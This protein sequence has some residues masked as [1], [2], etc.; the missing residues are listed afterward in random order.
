MKMKRI[1]GQSFKEAE[2]TGFSAEDFDFLPD[3]L[4]KKDGATGGGGTGKPEDGK[5]EDEEEDEGAGEGAAGTGGDGTGSG[6]A[7]D[8][9]DDSG[10]G[11]SDSF[12]LTEDESEAVIASFEGK[13]FNEAG[14]LLNEEGEVVATAAEIEESVKAVREEDAANYVNRVAS[15]KGV[16]LIDDNGAELEFSNDEEGVTRL[17][18]TTYEKGQQD[19]ANALFEKY[20][21]MEVL[22]DFLDSGKSLNEFQAHA[23]RDYSQYDLKDDT[24]KAVF[25]SL[26]KEKLMLINGMGEEEAIKQ[27]GRISDEEKKAEAE[28]ALA[29]LKEHKSAN[30]AAAKENAKK[31]ALAEQQRVK[32]YWTDRAKVIQSGK[33]AFGFNVSDN[34]KKSFMEYLAKPV[35]DEQQSAYMEAQANMPVDQQLAYAFLMFKKFDLSKL[36]NKGVGAAKVNKLKAKLDKSKKLRDKGGAGNSGAGSGVNLV[37]IPEVGS[38]N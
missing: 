1:T 34:E 22:K 36:I 13:E 32:D 3:N 20:P 24:P 25:D 12:T 16:R 2:S 26:V 30:E 37:T 29:S 14:D 28:A 18:D 4:I 17:I 5:T 11:G 7:V 15:E 6:G 35:N 38:Y 9:N 27:V 8:D 10:S 33:L 21:Q 23:S 31:A 19:Y